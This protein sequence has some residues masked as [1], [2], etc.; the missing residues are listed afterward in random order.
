M[1]DP[2]KTVKYGL[3]RWEASFQ[4]GRI[5]YHFPGWTE[6]GARKRAQEFYDS[7]R[8]DTLKKVVEEL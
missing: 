7:L 6:R 2:I 5:G 8:Q 1:E 3:L 4:H